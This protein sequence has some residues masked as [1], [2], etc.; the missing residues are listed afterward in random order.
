M[1][2]FEIIGY[3]GYIAGAVVILTSKTKND[4]LNDLKDRVDIL[5]K[6]RENARVQHLENQKAIA[7][8]E[9]QLSTY[10]EIPLKSIAASLESLPLLVQSNEEILKTLNKSATT[11]ASDRN[12]KVVQHIEKQEVERKE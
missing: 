9:G 5:E 8:L 6:D 4:N 10:K 11:V 12:K 7:N 1:D 2:V 3:V